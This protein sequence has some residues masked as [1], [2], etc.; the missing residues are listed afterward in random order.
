MKHIS[1][2]IPCLN[3]EKTISSCIKEALEGIENSNYD[4]EV[5]VSDNGS[6][7]N[8][9]EISKSLGAK[10]VITD[11]K[12]YGSAIINGI[13]NATG[14]YVIVGDADLT[15]NFLDIPNFVYELENNSDLVIGN[16][17]K[18]GIEKGAMPFLNK[19]IGNPFLSMIAR[20]FFNIDIGD[21]HCGLRGIKNSVYKNLNFKSTGM[22]FSIEMILKAALMSYSIKE[23]PTTLRKPPYDRVPH[24]KPFRDGFRHLYLI[25]SYTL[26]NNKNTFVNFINFLFGGL[27]FSLLLFSP[28]KISNIEF[29]T[30]SL[31]VANLLFLFSLISLK[32]KHLIRSLLLKNFSEHKFKNP[33]F[34]FII[35]FFNLLLILYVTYQWYKTGFGSLNQTLNI[36]IFSIILSTSIYVFFTF[37]VEMIYTAS[38]FFLDD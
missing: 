36:K 19:Y 34:I 11:V 21:F 13:N 23:I 25:F 37:F 7:D 24:L 15:Y 27:Y 18:G 38:K 33:I 10:V 12:G 22:E 5:I 2:V 20:L 26:V 17:F 28:L 3:E 16:R 6:T 4:G 14:E 31:L 8:S 32:F 35:L 9:V 29:S 1:V 30:L